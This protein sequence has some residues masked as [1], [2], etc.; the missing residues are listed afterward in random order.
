ME[1]IDRQIA[2]L[3]KKLNI[4]G[5]SQQALNKELREDG[6]FEIFHLEKTLDQEYHQYCQ[7]QPDPS[8]TEANTNQQ[9][10]EEHLEA[11]TRDQATQLDSLESII[12]NRNEFQPELVQRI[13]TRLKT[14][15]L[16]TIQATLADFESLGVTDKAAVLNELSKLTLL[17]AM[18]VD[19]R[20]LMLVLYL[21]VFMQSTRYKFLSVFLHHL[22]VAVRACPVEGESGLL[23]TRLIYLFHFKLVNRDVLVG[24]ILAELSELTQAPSA[25]PGRI[26]S[27]ADLLKKTGFQIRRES[28]KLIQ[29]LANAIDECKSESMGLI[30]DIIRRIKLNQFFEVKFC[31]NFNKIKSFMKTPKLKVTGYRLKEQWAFTRL[32]TDLEE[33]AYFA[34]SW[35]KD[36]LRDVSTSFLTQMLAKKNQFAAQLRSLALPSRRQESIA[37]CVL[38][39]KDFRD[40][41][42]NV[43]QL[44]IFRSKW[45]EISSCVLTMLSNEKEFNV[46]YVYL[47]RELVKRIKGLGYSFVLEFWEHY[48]GLT[49]E[50]AS[51]CKDAHLIRLMVSLIKVKTLDF[52]LFKNLDWSTPHAV[53]KKFN[54]LFFKYLLRCLNLTRIRECMEKLALNTQDALFFDDLKD[55]VGDYQNQYFARHFAKLKPEIRKIKMKAIDVFKLQF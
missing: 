23:A 22:A 43:F 52:K 51:Q 42:H 2:E 34:G 45:R 14:Q 1:D 41:A 55:F 47:V 38:S 3:E 27:L 44:G 21:S 9:P 11:D 4:S 28:P 5:K 50:G 48:V 35:A 24:Y 37:L 8:L 18:Q 6:L 39:G 33:G 29:H 20:Y 49:K 53:Q 15:R 10:P 32:S 7:S 31:L 40:A 26:A 25:R 16:P 13:L 19:E 12:T 17:G 54:V 30:G 46:F 36:N